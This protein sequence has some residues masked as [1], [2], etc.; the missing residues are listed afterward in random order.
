MAVGGP[1][2]YYSVSD[3]VSAARKSL[4][5]DAASAG[6]PQT[7]ASD[8]NTPSV[9]M[10]G[11]ANGVQGAADASAPW[12]RAAAM[13]GLDE[14]LRFD[15]TVDWI[16]RHWPRV[17]TGLP[18]V[19]LQGYRVPLVTGTKLSDV[20]GSLTYYFDSRQQAQRITLRGTTGDPRALVALLEGRFHFVRRLTN[21]PSIA[22]YEAVDAGN[23]PVGDVEDSFGQRD[24][25]EPTV[26]AIRAGLGCR[27]AGIVAECADAMEMGNYPFSGRRYVGLVRT[28]GP[29]YRRPLNGQYLPLRA[30]T[31][32]RRPS[33]W[34]WFRRRGAR[35]RTPRQTMGR[36]R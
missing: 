29:T 8:P 35:T 23:H 33:L 26:H 32:L 30:T 12:A 27:P 25:I 4:S 5:P 18:Q 14:V 24:L 28:I 34:A 6:S 17:S 13:P 2:G 31:P 20:A 15:V 9:G 11:L 36:R 22:Y 7:V 1:V 21:D 16:T 3:I 19:Q 10:S